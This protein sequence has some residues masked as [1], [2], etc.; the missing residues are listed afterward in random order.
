VISK[1][2][3]P[4]SDDQEQSARFI[5]TAKQVQSDNPKKAFEE[6]ISRIAKKNQTSKS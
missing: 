3:K 5:E 4:K 2:S 1:K 6:A